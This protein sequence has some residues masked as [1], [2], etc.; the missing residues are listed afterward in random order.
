MA[1]YKKQ[2]KDQNG[3]NIIPALGTATVTS[4]NIDWSTLRTGTPVSCSISY[5]GGSYTATGFGMVAV[6]AAVEYSANVTVYLNDNVVGKAQG[7]NSTFVW[8]TIS[9][10][11]CAGD[12]V[13]VTSSDS[14]GH[15]QIMQAKFIPIV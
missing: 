6:I 14:G 15:A 2:L 11:V 5:Q 13:K 10:P 1:T 9:V 12:V 4:T 3:N 8:T 7:G